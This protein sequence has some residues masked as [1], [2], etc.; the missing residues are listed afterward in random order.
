M[1]KKRLRVMTT[2]EETEKAHKLALKF[3][4]RII[5]GITKFVLFSM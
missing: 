2:K 1:K 5:I 3:S 4:E